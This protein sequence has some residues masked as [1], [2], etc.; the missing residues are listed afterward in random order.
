MND[1]DWLKNQRFY[2]RKFLAAIFWSISIALSLHLFLEPGRIFSGGLTGAAQLISELFFRVL[3]SARG[4]ILSGLFS[5]A[6]IIFLLNVPLFVIAWQQIGHR[7]TLFTFVAVVSSSFAIHLMQGL[8][9]LTHDPLLSAIF[10]GLLIGCGTG[11][12]LRNG[13]STGGVDIIGL[14]L[15]R[16]T[17]KSVGNIGIMVNT[18]ICLGSAYLNGWTI[19]LYSVLGIYIAGRV[20]DTFYSQQQRVQ[21]T[22]ITDDTKHIVAAIQGRYSRGITIMHNAEGGYSHT[23]RDVIILIISRDELSG[24]EQV[25]K[26]TDPDAFT[27]VTPV[28]RIQGRFHESKFD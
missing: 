17:G 4:G 21:L 18:V 6:T 13:I 22:I 7:F 15:R 12:A 8:P 25:V 23:A 24:A 14:V 26:R 27:T 28:E 9:P 1:F 20:V 2:V 10:G 16:V 5:V 19:A 11:V 3:P